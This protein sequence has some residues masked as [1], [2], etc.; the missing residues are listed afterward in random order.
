MV[1]PFIGNFKV[2]SPRGNRVLYG[3]DDYHKGMDLV[4]LDDINIYA[5]ADGV[6]DATPYEANGFGYYVRQKLPNG[7]RIYYGHMA[8]KSVC[9]VPGQEIRVGDRLGIM[10]STGQSTGAHTHIEIRPAGTG[11]ESEDI[12]A[13]TGIPN[14]NGTYYYSG[15]QEIIAPE[16]TEEVNEEMTQE[17]FNQFMNNYLTE[18]S[19]ESP[20]AW[21]AAARVWA[22]EHGL[23]KG[24]QNGNKQYKKFATR[25]EIA[26]ILYRMWQEIE[27]E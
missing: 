1:S 12:S 19:K 24:D 27:G 13:F 10:G 7:K 18:L 14:A 2:T 3:K 17:K 8:E 15:Q 23:I 22:E 5:I 25:E 6:V 20:N 21:S 4:G 11:Y 26:Q 16:Q 9:V